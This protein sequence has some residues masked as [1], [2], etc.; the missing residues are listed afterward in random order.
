MYFK[1]H[2]AKYYK[3]YLVHSFSCSIVHWWRWSIVDGSWLIAMAH[4]PKWDFT[5]HFPS[6]IFHLK[7][8]TGS[9]GHKTN[10]PYTC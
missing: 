9:K 5:F 8:I 1:I 4:K 3:V 6:Y 7:T 10:R 2:R